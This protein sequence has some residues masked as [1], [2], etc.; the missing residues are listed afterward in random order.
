LCAGVL[1]ANTC[2]Q[3]NSLNDFSGHIGSCSLSHLQS[4]TMLAKFAQHI[5]TVLMVLLSL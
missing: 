2:V 4:T 3:E 5:V 1:V